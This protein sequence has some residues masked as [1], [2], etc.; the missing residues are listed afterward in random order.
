MK[1][2]ETTSKTN[3]DTNTICWKRSILYYMI[4]IMS[5]NGRVDIASPSTSKLF[6]MYDKI[7]AKQCTTYRSATEGI[8]DETV[9]ST[10]FFSTENIKILQNGIRAGVY[11]RSNSQYIVGQQDCDSLKIIMRAMFLQ[12]SANGTE[13]VREQ[14]QALNQLVLDYS[15]KQ[16]YG[17]AK[18]YLKYMNDVST[19]PVPMAHPVLMNM[20]NKD[21]VMKEW[22]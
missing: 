11:K 4:L 6:Q 5:N 2:R 21:L 12:Y 3:A 18:G 9:L 22:F 17:E 8:W 7:P 19:L 1:R 10:A 16:V 14:I 15:I 20:K 13:N